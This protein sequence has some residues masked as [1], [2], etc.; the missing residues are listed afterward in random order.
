MKKNSYLDVF[1][2]SGFLASFFISFLD[3]LYISV[4]LSR[5]DGRVIA[6]GS[7]MS[8]AFPVFIGLFLGNP[9]LFRRLF[10]ILPVVMIA[11]L[12]I[13]CAA[14]FVAALNLAAYYLLTMFILGV[15]SASVV[16]LM[17]KLKERRY[18]RARASFDRKCAIADAGGALVGS[19]LSFWGILLFRDPLSIAILGALQTVVVYGLFILLYRRF[20]RRERALDEEPHPWRS[21]HAAYVAK[22]A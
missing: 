11:E 22:A 3:P 15:F 20:P 12:S 17:Q 7:I 9:R 10:A 14:A 2:I 6:L 18:R 1:V 8:S 5:I 21:R 4:I 13:G 16:Y 19:V